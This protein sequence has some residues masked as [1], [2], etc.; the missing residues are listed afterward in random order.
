MSNN[1]FVLA[2]G[3]LHKTRLLL[4]LGHE[5]S[6]SS[7]D[8]H[9]LLSGKQWGKWKWPIIGFIFFGILKQG[10]TFELTRVLSYTVGNGHF[11]ELPSISQ[12]HQQFLEQNFFQVGLIPS[13]IRDSPFK[14]LHTCLGSCFFFFLN[15]FW[16]FPLWRSRKESN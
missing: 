13:C 7:S 3:Q 2:F 1:E 16:E 10:L 12:E 4:Y 9:Y 14:Q 6:V 5:S 11:M 15:I 8:P